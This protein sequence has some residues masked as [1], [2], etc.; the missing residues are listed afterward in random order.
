MGMFSL[1]LHFAFLGEIVDFAEAM[2]LY[3]HHFINTI[4]PT[5]LKQG[6]DFKEYQ[7]LFYRD[8]EPYIHSSISLGLNPQPSSSTL[9]PEYL[10]WEI[11]KPAI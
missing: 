11:L 1:A 3:I 5:A 7:R 2:L 8:G 9:F 6:C 4:L 10:N